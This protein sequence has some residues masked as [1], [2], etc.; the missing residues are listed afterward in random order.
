MPCIIICVSVTLLLRS[1]GLLTSKTKKSERLC[2]RNFTGY[3]VGHIYYRQTKEI[4]THHMSD[5][6]A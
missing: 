3:L 5:F 4:K 2:L 6:L 1:S